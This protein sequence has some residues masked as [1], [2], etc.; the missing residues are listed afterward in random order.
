MTQRVTVQFC[1]KQHIA[2]EFGNAKGH[3]V[4]WLRDIGLRD[5]GTA[6][7][8]LMGKQAAVLVVDEHCSHCWIGAQRRQYTSM[9][10]QR[11]IGGV[12]P[13]LQLAVCVW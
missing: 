4:I 13:T 3:L 5:I 10:R 7:L 8:Q 1:P 2:L 11:G 12:N 6:L 9:T